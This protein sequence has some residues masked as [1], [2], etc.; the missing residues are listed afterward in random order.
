MIR[1][2]VLFKN[3]VQIIWEDTIFIFTPTLS[4]D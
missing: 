1:K 3:E 4:L 2:G